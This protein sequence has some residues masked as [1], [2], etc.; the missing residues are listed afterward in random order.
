LRRSRA[1]QESQTPQG[2][3]SVLEKMSKESPEADVPGRML[4]LTAF[5]AVFSQVSAMIDRWYPDLTDQ[6]KM[7]ADELKQN[8]TMFFKK[9]GI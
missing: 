6:H 2:I 4:A 5:T 7:E 3:L 9:M 8:I 1:G